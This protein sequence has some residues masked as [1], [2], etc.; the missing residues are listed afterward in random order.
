MPKRGNILYNLINSTVNNGK[1]GQQKAKNRE[2]G[3]ML[4][5]F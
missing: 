1:F 2:Q 3:I 4:A 5:R